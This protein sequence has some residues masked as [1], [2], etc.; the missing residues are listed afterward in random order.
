MR[1]L[2]GNPM[3]SRQHRPGAQGIL[4]LA[5]L[6]LSGC[7]GCD[8]PASRQ[9]QAKD[10]PAEEAPR[11]TAEK[12]AGKTEEKTAKAGAE[13]EPAQPA[14]EIPKRAEVPA[15]STSGGG[16][17]SSE[18][19]PAGGAEDA[20]KAA[21]AQR[22]ART[23]LERAQRAS[24]EGDPGRAFTF[25]AEAWRRVSPHNDPASRELASQARGLCETH[26]QAA[27]GAVRGVSG[28]IQVIK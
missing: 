21:Q 26:G 8:T 16:T 4:A 22:E 6:F 20:P 23:L 25:A 9:S 10:K 14:P 18:S 12:T 19:S 15:K 11:E 27:N 2:Q 1:P 7:G 3:T 17:P 5:C 13:S 28:K 24:S